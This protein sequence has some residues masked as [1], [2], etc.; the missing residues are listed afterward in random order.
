MAKVQN[1]FFIAVQRSMYKVQFCYIWYF[2]LYQILLSHIC[3]HVSMIFIGALFKINLF[4]QISPLVA[5]PVS[6]IIVYD[7]LIFAWNNT[8]LLDHV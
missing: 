1:I 5:Y 7:H 8:L 6:F 3:F 4:Y 2:C